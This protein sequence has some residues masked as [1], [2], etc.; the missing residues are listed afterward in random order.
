MW[1][2]LDERHKDQGDGSSAFAQL[3]MQTRLKEVIE[4]SP[5]YRVHLVAQLRELFGPLDPVVREVLGFG[6]EQAIRMVEGTGSLVQQGVRSWQEEFANDA[7][8]LRSALEGKNEV[9]VRPGEAELLSLLAKLPRRYRME[10]LRAVVGA[11]YFSDLHKAFLVTPDELAQATDSSRATALAFVG[12]SVLVVGVV[13]FP[14]GA[15]YSAVKVL[16]TELAVRDGAGEID[17]VVAIGQLKDE[18]FELVESDMTAVVHA[19]A[20]RP[21]KGQEP[22]R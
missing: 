16:E 3:R 19:A 14:F 9:P 17:M 10:R 20:G 8:R 21:V 2:I 4:R 11:A 15:T 12:S 18:Q 7:K 6:V 22:Y 5:G 1:E 13:G